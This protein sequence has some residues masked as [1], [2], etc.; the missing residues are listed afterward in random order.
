MRKIYFAVLALLVF[1]T[2][3][4]QLFTGQVIDKSTNEPIAYAQVYFPELKAGTVTNMKG[5]FKLE[6][7]TPKKLHIQISY[8]GYES[9]DEVINTESKKKMQFYLKQS[10]YQ[11]KEV[12]VSVPDGKLQGDNV[13][14]VDH[15][16]I[17]SLQRTAPIT[18]AEAISSIPGID[19]NTTG[20]GIGK[21][22]IRG[23]TGN[24]IVTY[25]QGIRVEN[26]QWG[27]E[28]GLGV[29]EVG[30]ESVEVIK[31]PASLLYGAD[32]MGGVLFFID[33][34]YA[35]ENTIEAKAKTSFLS[36]TLGS[37]NHLGFKIHKGPLKLNLFGG[38]S[39][40]ADYKVPNGKRVFN[41]RFDEKN[42][43]IALG[44]NTKNLVSNLRY[45]YLEND[46]GIVDSNIYSESNNREFELPFQNIVN[47]SIS[48]QNTLYTGE[49]KTSLTLGYTHNYRQEFEEQTNHP[50]L[51]LKLG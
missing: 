49:S 13:V 20:A 35:N 22:V 48:L 30:I 15:K 43:K 51:G 44:F 6:H 41:S 14:S 34:R 32:A 18:L 28:H 3:T 45:S 21:P 19:Q 23:L 24:R 2:A 9:I 26:Q 46:F 27:D 4:A 16:K 33:E 47:H 25:A 10:H 29:G 8:V 37:I 50:A 17:A 11:L 5:E 40:Q 12:V 38:Y 39:T 7:D 31:G 36:N 1:H 42:M